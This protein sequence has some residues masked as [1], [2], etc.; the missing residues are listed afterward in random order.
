MA[1][2]IKQYL[3]RNR[4]RVFGALTGLILALL[5]LHYGLLRAIFICAMV[6][7]GY[8][9]GRWLDD[10]QAGLSDLLDRFLP[11]GQR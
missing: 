8:V 5:I 7:I 3:S 11:N 1:D 6:V 2:D 9:V 4:G 10:D